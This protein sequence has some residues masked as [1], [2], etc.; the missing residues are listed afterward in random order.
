VGVG[1][2]ERA[3]RAEKALQLKMLKQKVEIAI[4]RA[5]AGDKQSQTLALPVN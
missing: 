3:P 4:A 2:S 5:R 1:F